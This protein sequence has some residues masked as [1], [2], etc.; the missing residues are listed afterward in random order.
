MENC[1]SIVFYVP[2]M[3]YT[4]I[5]CQWEV[6]TEN[7][8]LSSEQNAKNVLL[9]IHLRYYMKFF[10]IDKIHIPNSP[11]IKIKL[12][13]SKSLQNSINLCHTSVL[14]PYLRR[15]KVSSVQVKAC[16]WTNVHSF[17]P[18]KNRLKCYGLYLLIHI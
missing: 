2:T 6:Q 18:R 12:Q 14:N 11:K 5:G 16:N 15:Q 9:K 4:D 17:L 1:L 7:T 3:I 13:R 10:A 8:H